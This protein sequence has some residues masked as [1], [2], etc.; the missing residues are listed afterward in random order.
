MEGPR[1][2]ELIFGQESMGSGYLI[3][4]RHVL[5]ARHV[6]KPAARGTAC[7]VQPLMAPGQEHLP[8][9]QRKRPEP[10]PGAA[11]WLSERH[12]LAIVELTEQPVAGLLQEPIRFGRVPTSDLEPRDFRGSGFPAAAGRDSNLVTGKLAY[13]PTSWTFDLN[14]ATALP[15]D[16]RE[17][18]GFSGAA[19]FCGDRAV[20]VVRTVD[21]RWNGKLTATPAQQLIGDRRFTAFWEETKLEPLGI[22]ELV[23]SSLVLRIAGQVYLIDR[24]DAVHQVR[25]HV[26]KLLPKC[27]PQVVAI[28]GVDDDEHGFV[29]RQLADDQDMQQLLGRQAS[30][31]RVIAPLTWP[32]EIRQIDPDEWF[33][34]LIKEICA[35]ARVAPPPAGE[36]PPFAALRAAFDDGATPR[37]FWVLI[38]RKIAFGGHGRLLRLLLDFW[39][40]LGEG[41]LPI[42]LFLCLAWDEHEQQERQNQVALQRLL[43]LFNPPKPDVELDE[44]VTLAGSQ[45]RL[46]PVGPLED[47]ARDHV[48]PWITVLRSRCAVPSERLER[49]RLG[50]FNQIGAGKRMRHVAAGIDDLLQ[51]I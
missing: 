21:S 19:V 18:A 7:T 8:L 42:L 49:L 47:I 29:I 30:S 26:N 10:L 5:T 4:P 22:D 6:V 28:L 36:T 2:V 27:A 35:V 46:V 11:A 3:T 37:A 9:D 14:I 40:G 51:R 13:V 17:W 43:S 34:T 31:D 45:R 25:H 41:R 15:S 39:Q 12:D 16:Y 50:L 23:S 44:T 38:R 48:D 33:R 20:G 24:K 32:A 1:V